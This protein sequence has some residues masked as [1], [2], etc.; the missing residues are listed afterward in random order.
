MNVAKYI[1]LPTTN[2][3][4]PVGAPAGK[5]PQIFQGDA[6]QTGVH[7]AMRQASRH[8][9]AVSAVLHLKKESAGHRG[10]PTAY[11]S[12]NKKAFGKV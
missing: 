2:K 11:N 6:M 10:N 5:G 12:G 4:P 9:K 8:K 7:A 1:P 3:A